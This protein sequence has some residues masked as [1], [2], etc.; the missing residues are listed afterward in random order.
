[1]TK[2]TI[3]EKPPE[4]IKP[5]WGLV[6]RSMVALLNDDELAAMATNVAFITLLDEQQRQMVLQFVA[7]MLN[8]R[9]D[10][11]REHWHVVERNETFTLDV[12]PEQGHSPEKFS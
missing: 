10:E 3:P 4:F 11:L 2:Q 6:A 12:V 1:M 8:T 5:L 7:D 9:S